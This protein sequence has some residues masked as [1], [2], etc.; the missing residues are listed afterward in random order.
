MLILNE[1]GMI[2]HYKIVPNDKR[3]EVKKLLKDIWTTPNIQKTTSVVYTD[4]PKVDRRAIQEIFLDCFSEEVE[5]SVLL[6]I[7]HAKMRIIKDIPRSHPDY[8]VAKQD[9]AAIFNNIQKY[10]YYPLPQDLV[11]DF[12]TW[13]DKYSVV[14]STSYLSFDDQINYLA[15]STAAKK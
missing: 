13:V 3:D 2:V 8:R 4:N 12:D 5:V 11:D 14:Y 7:F 9:I 1:D 10:G 6:D 15:K